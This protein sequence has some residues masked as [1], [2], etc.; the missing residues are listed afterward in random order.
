MAEVPHLVAADDDR[1]IF[2]GRLGLVEGKALRQRE[3][4]D[5]LDEAA[6]L[7]GIGLQFADRCSVG[8]LG[9]ERAAQLGAADAAAVMVEQLDIVAAAAEALSEA[10]RLPIGTVVD[11]LVEGED[12]DFLSLCRHM[13][14]MPAD[15][16]GSVLQRASEPV[17]CRNAPP[18]GAFA[19]MSDA[20]HLP[21]LRSRT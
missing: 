14:E 17:V 1:V 13:G 18:R 11:A 4:G 9:L 21:N 7:L 5:R 16:A 2:G 19:R 12:S 20:K 8:E 3:L 10:A 15:C 6:G